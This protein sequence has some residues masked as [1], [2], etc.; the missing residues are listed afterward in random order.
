[1]DSL[2]RY[3]AVTILSVALVANPVQAQVI[4]D[5][6][7]PTAVSSLDNRNFAIEGGGRSGDNLFHSFSQFSVPTGGAV[8][9][10]HPADVRNIF[11]RVTGGAISNIDGLIQTNGA[12]NLFLLNPSGIIFGPKARLDI[13]GSF[14]GTTASQM[15]FADGVTFSAANPMPLLTMSLPIGVQMGQNPAGISIQGQGHRLKGSQALAPVGPRDIL[16]MVTD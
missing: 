1:M 2:S 14:L 10:N 12:A 11:S 6:T 16:R 8:I 5:N 3:A 7:L 9:F 4:P 13:G 15:Q